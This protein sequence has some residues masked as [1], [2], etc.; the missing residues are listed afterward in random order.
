LLEDE[1][2]ITSYVHN[3]VF[4][5]GAVAE[6]GRTL[7]LYWSGADEVMCAGTAVIEELVELCLTDSSPAT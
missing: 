2:E 5:C 3:V 1:W 7:K 4:T 6:D